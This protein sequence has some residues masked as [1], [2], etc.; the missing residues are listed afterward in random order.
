VERRRGALVQLEVRQL[1]VI[2]RGALHCEL[3]CCA[4]TGPSEQDGLRA[5]RNKACHVVVPSA[6]RAELLAAVPAN[7]QD[8]HRPAIV[9]R[10]AQREPLGGLLPISVGSQPGACAALDNVD[11]G[12]G[13]PNSDGVIPCL[14][15]VRQIAHLSQLG[16]PYPS[17]PSAARIDRA[18]FRCRMRVRAKPNSSPPRCHHTDGGRL[19][20][21]RSQRQGRQRCDRR[22]PAR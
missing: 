10:H 9:F 17:R 5:Y 14:R 12:R 16:R 3:D 18:S 20:N 2:K 22:L 15:E 7:P 13:H 4:R 21:H 11:A 6:E 8:V 1:Q 19:L